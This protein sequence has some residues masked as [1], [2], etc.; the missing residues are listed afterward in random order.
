[1]MSESREDQEWRGLFA[2]LHEEPEPLPSSAAPLFGDDASARSRVGLLITK[3]VLGDEQYRL[4][5]LYCG[6][7]MPRG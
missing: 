1:M 5:R 3:A 7:P 2:R 6:D 4:Y